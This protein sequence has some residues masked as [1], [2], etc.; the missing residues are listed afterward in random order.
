MLDQS[1]KQQLATRIQEHLEKSPGIRPFPA[2]VTRLL[3]EIKNVNSSTSSF[4]PI[5]ESDPSLALQVMRMVS[6][7]LFGLPKVKSIGHAIALLGT[8]KMRTLALSA[9]GANLFS[10]GASAKKQRQFIWNHSIGCGIVARLLANHIPTVVPEDA[11]LGGIFHDIGKLLFY[12]VVP[13]EYSDLASSCEGSELTKREDAAFGIN[14]Q[15]LGLRSAHDWQLPKEVKVA[16]GWHHN[17]LEA[18]VH[19]DV[20]K[21]IFYADAL[22]KSWNIGPPEASLVLPSEAMA[23]YQLD[24]STMEELRERATEAFEMSQT[25]CSL[26]QAIV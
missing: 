19:A 21:A 2:A 15:E 5:I 11:F 8:N 26:D 14:H 24:S 3:A 23:E 6:S 4:V 17:P 25:A 1:D 7:P 13:V 16:I 12:D 22:A 20:A 9:A 10:A 18:P